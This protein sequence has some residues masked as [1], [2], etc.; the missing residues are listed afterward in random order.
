MEENSG[1]HRRE[2]SG[3]R[4]NQRKRTINRGGTNRVKENSKKK[5]IGL[6]DNPAYDD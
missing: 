5:A 6:P 1:Y 2:R 4:A 3:R